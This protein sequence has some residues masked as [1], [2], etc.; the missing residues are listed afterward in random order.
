LLASITE[1]F[2]EVIP[3]VRLD[4]DEP[5]KEALLESKGLI[6]DNLR[7]S[8]KEPFL[9]VAGPMIEALLASN[10]SMIDILLPVPTT[11]A[12][13][14][15]DARGVEKFVGSAG[16]ACDA[17]VGSIIEARLELDGFNNELCLWLGRS[18]TDILLCPPVAP[19]LASRSGTVSKSSMFSTTL[20][21]GSI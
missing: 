18:A 16:S 3:E 13:R 7:E 4:F 17:S 2:L 6:I 21:P 15:L 11:E 5:T 8:V 1:A 10:G 12:F 19:L 14:E 20:L 9:G